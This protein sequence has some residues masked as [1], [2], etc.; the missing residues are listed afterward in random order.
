MIHV[1]PCRKLFLSGVMQLK[2]FPPR[3]LHFISSGPESPVRHEMEKRILSS[4]IGSRARGASPA[5]SRCDL[6]C[7]ELDER[8]TPEPLSG[9]LHGNA[10][11][12][13]RC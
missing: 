5:E 8:R 2:L 4:A 3:T 1:N 13:G 7:T 10:H 9:A 6:V 11:P 12:F